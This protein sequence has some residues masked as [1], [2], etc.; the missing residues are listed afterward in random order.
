[1]K[2]AILV[3][4]LLAIVAAGAFAAF[5]VAYALR[6]RAVARS[7]PAWWA[8]PIRTAGLERAFLCASCSGPL[9]AH[10]AWCGRSERPEHERDR[11]EVRG[12]RPRLDHSG[13]AQLA[14]HAALNRVGGGSN[15]P[16]RTKAPSRRGKAAA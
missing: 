10:A 3:V 4:A 1:M 5:A 14:E 8:R 13:L 12:T 15:P 2:A 6:R 16:A 11:R 9:V 7:L